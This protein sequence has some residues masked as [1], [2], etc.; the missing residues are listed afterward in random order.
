[1]R[2]RGNRR[3]KKSPRNYVIYYEVERG[4]KNFY[5]LA[6]HYNISYSRVHQIYAF[7][8]EERVNK[9]AVFAENFKQATG[10]QFS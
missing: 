9:P 7:V 5:D 8:L 3:Q 2:G 1:M 10:F 4:G 6:E